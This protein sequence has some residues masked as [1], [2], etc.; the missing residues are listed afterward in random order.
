MSVVIPCS[1]G[2]TCASYETPSAFAMSASVFRSVIVM[3]PLPA[4]HKTSSRDHGFV[5][6]F[7]CEG[8]TIKNV[9]TFRLAAISRKRASICPCASKWWLTV[10]AHGNESEGGSA[11]KGSSIEYGSL[12]CSEAHVGM[13][14]TVSACLLVRRKAHIHIVNNAAAKSALNNMKKC[15]RRV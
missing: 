7:Q 12:S 9:L 4:L 5:E 14:Y 1:S 8:L 10:A 2:N 3:R 15:R 13:K 6:R 11:S